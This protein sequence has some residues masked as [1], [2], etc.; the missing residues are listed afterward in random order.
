M[1]RSAID[2]AERRGVP[3]RRG[4]AVAQNHLVTVGR[5]EQLAQSVADPAHQVLHRRLPVR[6]AEQRGGTRAQRRQLLG[7]NFRR[8]APKPAVGRLDVG[9]NREHRDVSHGA[10][11]GVGSPAPKSSWTGASRR[12]K[13][14]WTPGGITGTVLYIRHLGVNLVEGRSWQGPGWSGAG[15]AI[16][17]CRTT[18]PT[19][20]C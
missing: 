20:T 16:W 12:R 13:S 18:L 2:Q 9:R 1:Q 11:L 10:S 15:A 19:S 8:A 17:R 14:V 7:A 6:R 5:A 4:S 3:E